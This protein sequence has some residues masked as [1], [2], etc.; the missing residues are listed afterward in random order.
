MMANLPL[1]LIADIL[2][3]LPVKQLLCFRCV[4]KLWRSLID[5]TDFIKLHLRH[6]LKSHTN[7]TLILKN[8]HLHAADLAFLGSFA[9]LD[10]PLMSYNHGVNILGSCNGLL[11]IRN[12]IEDMAIWNPF[13]RKH[14]VL[15]SLSSC[16]IGR[17]H[18]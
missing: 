9:K 14:Q 13:T 10:H 15:P 7:H 3:R 6:S 8:S 11:C 5:D 18:V 2:S 16:K 4:S 17:A 12:I 1:H